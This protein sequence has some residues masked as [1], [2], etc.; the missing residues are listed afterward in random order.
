VVEIGS[1]LDVSQD[2]QKMSFLLLLLPLISFIY[3]KVSLI[4]IIFYAIFFT[5]HSLYIHLLKS[6]KKQ[7]TKEIMFEKG[8]KYPKFWYIPYLWLFALLTII[9][10]IAFFS[11][12]YITILNFDSEEIFSLILLL[13]HV[14][15]VTLSIFSLL[16]INNL[17]KKVKRFKIKI[18]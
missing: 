4:L 2:I 13:L 11:S 9:N 15:V 18:K 1:V 7:V 3:F 10:I 6:F 8:D 17:K 14:M 5:I 12:F 16:F